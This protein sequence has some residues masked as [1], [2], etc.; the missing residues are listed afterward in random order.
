MIQ[1]V[2]WKRTREP[3]PEDGI[4]KIQPG[5]EASL[6]IVGQTVMVM[7][8]KVR[9]KRIQF[10]HA[11]PA[12]PANVAIHFSVFSGRRATA[13]L[14]SAMALAGLRPLGQVS[15]QFMMVWQR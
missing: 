12:T 3:I 9:K 14:M 11:A 5:S 13:F 15:V 7:F 2:L 8:K 1:G 10:A 4:G 6:E